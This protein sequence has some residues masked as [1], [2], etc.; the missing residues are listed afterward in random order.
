MKVLLKITMV[1]LTLQLT[2]AQTTKGTIVVDS[3]YSEN[4][5]NDFGENPTRK[6]GVYLPPNYNK[7]PTKYPVIYFLYG[8]YGDHTLLGSMKDILDFAIVRL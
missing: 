4:L 8:L 5:V 7:E 3:I 2:H 1:I 6:V